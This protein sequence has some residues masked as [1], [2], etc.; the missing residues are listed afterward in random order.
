MN[1]FIT[2][3]ADFI[4]SHISRIYVSPRNNISCIKNIKYKLIYKFFYNNP[5]LCLSVLNVNA[6]YQCL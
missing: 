6:H 5:K 4:G 2:G 3:I 1:I